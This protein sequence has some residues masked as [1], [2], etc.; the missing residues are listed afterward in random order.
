MLPFA[1]IKLKKNGN[2]VT[3]CNS[4]LQCYTRKF[5]KKLLY[6]LFHLFFVGFILLI[7][8]NFYINS[9]VFLNY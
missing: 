8:Y 3:K 5:K 2:N 9:F 4:K 6:F 7:K 1:V